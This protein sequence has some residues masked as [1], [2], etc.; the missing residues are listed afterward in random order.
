MSDVPRLLNAIDQGD[1]QAAERLLPLLSICASSLL[2]CWRRK[3]RGRRFK[4]RPWSTR[5]ICAWSVDGGPT[6]E[7]KVGQGLFGRIIAAGEGDGPGSSP[8]SAARV[9]GPLLQPAV[10]GVSRFVSAQQSAPTLA[11]GRELPLQTGSSPT[12][13]NAVDALFLDVA[14][15]GGHSAVTLLIDVAPEIVTI[16]RLLPSGDIR[17]TPPSPLAP[18]NPIAPPSPIHDLVPPSAYRGCLQAA[19]VSSDMFSAPITTGDRGGVAS[20]T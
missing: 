13:F 18:P 12:A 1:P 17:D 16:S 8:D 15:G 19:D 4:P 2:T 3:S 10:S 14:P 9:K 5:P 7:Q 11:S 6:L 20:G